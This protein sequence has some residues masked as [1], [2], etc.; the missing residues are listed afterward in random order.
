MAADTSPHIKQGLCQN[1]CLWF[2]DLIYK[3][4]KMNFFGM[5]RQ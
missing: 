5:N 3:Q 4:F 2:I 1:E